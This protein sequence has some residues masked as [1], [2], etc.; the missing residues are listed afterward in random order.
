MG[1]SGWMFLLVPAYPGSPRQKAVKRLYVCMCIHLHYFWHYWRIIVCG[2]GSV[3]LLGPPFLHL[4]VHDITCPQLPAGDIDWQWQPEYLIETTGKTWIISFVCSSFIATVYSKTWDCSCLAWYSLSTVNLWYYIRQLRV[5][6][7]DKLQ[8]RS[9]WK[10]LTA[11]Q[12]W[13]LHHLVHLSHS[14]HLEDQVR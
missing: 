11:L 1:V 13:I 4:S 2:A 3:K 14:E 12:T 9:D 6:L 7:V 5:Q 10:R 8:I